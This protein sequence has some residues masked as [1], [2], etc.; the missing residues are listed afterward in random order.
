MADRRDISDALREAVDRTVQATVD[1]RERAQ[2]AVD[3]LVKGAERGGRNVRAAVEDR[4]PATQDDVKEIKSELR[5]IDRRLDE[6][7][8]RLPAK[9]KPTG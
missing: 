3:D 4:L 6:I 1:T 5:K 2:D 7:E 8:K 9:A